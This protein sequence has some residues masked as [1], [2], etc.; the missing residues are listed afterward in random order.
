MLNLDSHF[1]K[2]TG[3][4]LVIFYFEKKIVIAEEFGLIDNSN[5]VVNSILSKQENIKSIKNVII[6]ALDFAISNHLKSILK[7]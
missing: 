1:S 4:I 7:K 2:I 6:D 5:R 3:I